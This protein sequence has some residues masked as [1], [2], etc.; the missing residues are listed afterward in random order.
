MLLDVRQLIDRD[1]LDRITGVAGS[2]GATIL[3]AINKELTPLLELRATSPMSLTVSVGNIL[4]QNPST[5]SQ[6]TIPP[7]NG[8]I[9]VF[10]SGSVVFPSSS[11][12][13]ATPSAGSPIV[14]TVGSGNFIKVTMNLDNVGNIVI[15]AGAQGA[16]AAAA[17]MPSPPGNTFA[18][19]YVLLQNIGGVIQNIPNSS[20]F[21]FL[22]GSGSG[23]DPFLTARIGNVERNL[24]LNGN[25]DFWQRGTTRVAD[26]VTP[27]FFADR[28]GWASGGTSVLATVTQSIDVPTIAQSNFASRYSML[29][30]TNNQF[31]SPVANTEHYIAYR[32]EGLDY[33]QIHARKC[34]IQFWVKS[35]LSGTFPL[36]LSNG[37]GDRSYVTTY[38]V[39][40]ANVW[41]KVVVDMN[42]DNT[43][44]WGLDESIGLVLKF[45]VLSG[46][47]FDSA[48][49]NTWQSGDFVSTLGAVNLFSGP[50]GS[51]FQLAQVM[52]IPQDFT[53]N[54]T[55]DIPFQ[56]AGRS[57]GDELALCQR[58]FEKSYEITTT[59][60]TNTSNNRL[61]IS[62]ISG[63]NVSLGT[64]TPIF[65]KVTKRVPPSMVLYKVDGT[66]GNLDKFYGAGTAG[67]VTVN[68]SGTGTAEL[69]NN[70][71]GS[72]MVANG[73]VTLNGH[74]TADSE[75]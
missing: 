12:G 15:V 27:T 8:I 25:M 62:A 20:I 32:M 69:S 72:G 7:I 45:P 11:G 19:G 48:S 67:Q 50:V 43:G 5:L 60:G 30:T 44:T 36:S 24:V 65:H 29:F 3:A 17:T 18:I 42:L 70:N 34:R 71:T 1:L 13:S 37:G 49:L 6:R 40:V 47:N 52:I 51:T 55:L 2:T 38:A 14:I 56:R 35:S 41:Q 39:P 9:P 59:P 16:T 53:P 75:F 73:Y 68:V 10:T 33:E 23:S 26:N 31:V 63:S 28:F 64:S 58:Y 22:G 74:Y 54:P 46:S 4:Q 21:Q 61:S 57:I 66:P